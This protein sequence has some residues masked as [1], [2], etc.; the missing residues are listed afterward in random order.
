MLLC[1]ACGQENPDAARFCL[2]CGA[3]LSAEGPAGEERRIVTVIFVDL[4]GSTAL[5]A[6]PTMRS[7]VSMPLLRAAATARTIVVSPLLG[8]VRP[9]A[10]SWSGGRGGRKGNPSTAAPAQL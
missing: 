3:A 6:G 4:V 8:A 10:R 1:R 7:R 9:S 5:V 2:A